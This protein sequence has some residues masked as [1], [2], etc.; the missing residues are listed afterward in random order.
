MISNTSKHTGYNAVGG[1]YSASSE[2][3]R[4]RRDKLQRQLETEPSF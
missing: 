2:T 1:V 4:S 3:K